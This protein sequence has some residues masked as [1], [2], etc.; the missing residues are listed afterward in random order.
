MLQ[1]RAAG[2]KLASWTLD[3]TCR[4]R[5][6][7]TYI[8][9]IA[10][11]VETA[12]AQLSPPKT[13]NFKCLPN[14]C[15]DQHEWCRFWAS[16]GECKS[17][18]DWM[19]SNCQLACST[20][21]APAAPEAQPQG[22]AAETTAA[23]PVAPQQ[24]SGS[25]GS[26]S[27]IAEKPQEAA[28]QLAAGGLVNPVEDLSSRVLLS[29]DDITRSVSSGC[30]PQLAASECSQSLCYHLS[31]RSFD[32]VCNNLKRP[33]VGA[34]FRTYIRLLP[35]EY[36]NGFSEPAS[37][38]KNTRPSVREASRV[39]L[40]SSQVVTH[41][42]FNSLLMQFGQ[43]M[44]H[45]MAKTTLQPTANCASCDPVP[46]KCVPVHISEKDTNAAFKQK[47]CLKISPF[48][49]GSQI[50]GSSSK[51]LHKFREGRTGMLKMSR[52]NSQM[53]LP[54]DQSKCSGESQCTASF[55][56]GDIRA[57]LFLGLSSMHILFAREH[58][59]LAAELQRLNAAW[60]G[61]RVFQE[62]RKIVGAEIQSILYK[63]F[64]PNCGSTISNVFTTSAYRFGHGMLLENYP[65]LMDNGQEIS[66]GSFNFGDGVFKSNKIL[67]E[68][69]ID[70]I[71]RGFWNTAVKRPHRMTP[72]ITERMF[73]STDLGSLNI[74]RGREHG[75][76]SY[77]KWRQF[78][79]LPAAST[80]ES[81]KDQILDD[82]VRR[83]LEANYPS[84]DDVDLRTRD[85]DRFY[86]ENKG[87][88]TAAQ[89]AEIEKFSLSRV[90]CDNGDHITEV[91]AQG[92]LLPRATS[93]VPC[94]QIP[95]IDLSK[96][97]E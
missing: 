51:D 68:G 42:S 12:T 18:S 32:G 61:D 66:Q 45:D 13:N 16:I 28:E 54:F 95:H 35:P 41:D 26:C 87:I 10:I 83:G 25:G 19:I 14:G 7:L 15:C 71:L 43:F 46:S 92:F 89:L 86:F 55:V 6:R 36:D 38:L 82:S 8:L 94:A 80:F 49:D 90:L 40:S 65:R 73:G 3:I 37:S 47:K 48:V 53:V 77:N 22:P 59:R 63:E 27:Q 70:P 97:K 78:C 20:C 52:F 60:S 39:L 11:F 31:Y 4:R 76:P 58:N 24:S 21:N 56:A 33:L 62:A 79:G 74:M 75:I 81:L 93:I 30:V 69:G 57:N 72:A 29:I 1:P 17:N 64:L 34:A 2:D 91:P 84:P 9:V 50:Y 85:G 5:N 88:F 44:S 23:A 67:F 96:W